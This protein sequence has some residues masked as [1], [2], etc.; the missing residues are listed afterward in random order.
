M[1]LRWA[2]IERRIEVTENQNRPASRRV[3]RRIGDNSRRRT[4]IIVA[5]IAVALVGVFVAVVIADRGQQGG[6]T[7]PE[8]VET[9]ENLSRDHTPETVSYPQ[10]PPVGGEHAPQWQNAG[11]YSEPISN[12]TGVHTLEHGAVWITYRPDLPE[13][14][15]DQIRELV[16]GQTCVLASP[17]PDLPAPVV[18]SAWERRLSLEGADDPDLER[19]VSTFRQGLQT[20]E[21]GAACTG[22]VGEAQ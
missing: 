7:P 18:A 15:V 11:F 12:E 19:F 8:G 2:F 14:Q 17:Y 21:P 3:S 1:R 5:L 22:G 13:E 16:N 20:P 9:F 10:S 4:S 6:N